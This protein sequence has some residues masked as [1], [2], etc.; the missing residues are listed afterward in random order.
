LDEY[1]KELI[2]EGYNEIYE[3]IK[4]AYNDDDY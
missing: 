4:D 3:D 1:Q 2:E